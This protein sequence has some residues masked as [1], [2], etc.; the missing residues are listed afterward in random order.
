MMA[1]VK[2][3]IPWR[4]LT[5]E[6]S[7]VRHHIQQSQ[8]LV[9]PQKAPSTPLLMGQALLL[10]NLITYM[11]AEMNYL[12]MLAPLSADANPAAAFHTMSRPS[13]PIQIQVG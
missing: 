6:A 7:A 3:N 11:E 9:S 2:A 8:Q 4:T 1:I 12:T 5:A 13:A 10:L